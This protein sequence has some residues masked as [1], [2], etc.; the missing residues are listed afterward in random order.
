MNFAIFLRNLDEILREFLRNVQVITKCFEILR[1]SARKIRNMLE[2]SG[3]L[4]FSEFPGLFSRS[5]GI[6][7]FPDHFGEIPAKIHQFFAEK[8]QNSS[9]NATEKSA[10]KK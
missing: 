9:K 5:L 2:I 4:G 7:S 1:K 8:S 6:F 3:S 10:R